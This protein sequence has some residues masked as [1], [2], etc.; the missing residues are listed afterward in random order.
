M[1]GFEDLK[2]WRL[3]NVFW[4]ND[5]EQLNIRMKEQ[6]NIRTSEAIK[7]LKALFDRLSGQLFEPLNAKQ[8]NP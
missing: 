1:W 6:L 7:P 5:E 3:G 4:E 2:M 8:L